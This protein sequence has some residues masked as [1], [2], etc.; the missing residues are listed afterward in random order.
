MKLASERSLNEDDKTDAPLLQE[1]YQMLRESIRKDL[2]L[3]WWA[4]PVHHGQGFEQYP[5]F[6]ALA[7][8]VAVLLAASPRE[9]SLDLTSV[10]QSHRLA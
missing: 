1:A 4:S 3:D 5:A 2:P 10:K 6:K 8:Y 9:E 7:E